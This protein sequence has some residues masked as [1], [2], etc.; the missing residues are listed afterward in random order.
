LRL[1]LALS[2]KLFNPE[3]LREKLAGARGWS[4][5][6]RSCRESRVMAH[7]TEALKRD[8]AY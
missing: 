8:D 4:S 7:K 2:V 1:W 6:T 3:F 5:A